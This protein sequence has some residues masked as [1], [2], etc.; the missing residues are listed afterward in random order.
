VVLTSQTV[1]LWLGAGGG[2]GAFRAN[3]AGVLA[4]RRDAAL[5]LPAAASGFEVWPPAAAA[6]GFARRAPGRCP[7]SGPG[8]GR[9]DPRHRDLPGPPPQWRGGPL[10]RG[11]P[12]GAPTGSCPQ[13]SPNS[14]RAPDRRSPSGPL[15]PPPPASRRAPGQPTIPDA[16]QG[17]I[18][19]KDC[20]AH[21]TRKPR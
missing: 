19:W 21:L 15:W 14:R 11:L 16:R 5:S 9:S 6:P 3:L 4:R 18:P 12:I 10:R 7:P 1:G 13:R 20:A 2:L 8:P 17:A